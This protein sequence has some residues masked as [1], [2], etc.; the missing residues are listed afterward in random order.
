MLRAINIKRAF[1]GEISRSLLPFLAEGAI[2]LALEPVE[3]DFIEGFVKILFLS[4][5]HI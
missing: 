1:V 3:K 2:L 4:L 5:I